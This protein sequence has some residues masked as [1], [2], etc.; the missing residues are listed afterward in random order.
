[1]PY[2]IESMWTQQG[3]KFALHSQTKPEPLPREKSRFRTVVSRG[4]Q[5]RRSMSAQSCVIVIAFGARGGCDFNEANRNPVH[6]HHHTTNSCEHHWCGT[7]AYEAVIV[8]EVVAPEDCG[9]DLRGMN[10]FGELSACSLC[11][12][13]IKQENIRSQHE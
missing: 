6:G 3:D 7:A 5:Y 13:K 4:E 12:E 10:M 11:L 9:V 2:L 8:V 1:M